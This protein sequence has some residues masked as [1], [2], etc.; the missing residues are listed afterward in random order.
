VADHHTHDFDIT[1]KEGI[2]ALE[3]GGV[4]DCEFSIEMH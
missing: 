3:E 4:F 1:K 2:I